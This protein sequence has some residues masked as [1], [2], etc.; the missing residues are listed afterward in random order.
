MEVERE[1][2]CITI[3]PGIGLDDFHKCGISKCL[4]KVDSPLSLDMMVDQIESGDILIL[5]VLDCC[6]KIG[7]CCYSLN[8]FHLSNKKKLIIHA[9]Y[10]IRYK[11]WGE[12]LTKKLTSIAKI[13]GCSSIIG[14]GRKGWSRAL[15]GFSVLP[16]IVMEKEI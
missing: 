16:I 6:S 14:M 3:R 5:E 10:G 7:G 11:S 4:E 15:V 9:I 8:N 1:P 13:N 2:I 12:F